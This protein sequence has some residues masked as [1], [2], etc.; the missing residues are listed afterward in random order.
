MTDKIVI[1]IASGLGAGYFPFAPGTAGSAAGVLVAFLFIIFS[2]LNIF[3]GLIYAL[4]TIL[5]FAVGVWSA[6]RAEVIYGEKDC[7]KIVIDEIAGILVTLYL[8]PY[9][10]RWL[11]AGFILFRLFDITKPFPARRIDQRVKGGWGVMLDDVA[12]GIYANIALR[13]LVRVAS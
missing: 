4:L 1:A 9:D 2:G 13:I 6:G 8:I 11:L 12:A 3:S 10:W 7:G 5:V